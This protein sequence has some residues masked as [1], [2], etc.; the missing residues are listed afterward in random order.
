MAGAGYRVRA[1]ELASAGQQVSGLV[2]ECVQLAGDVAQAVSALAA[3]AGNPAVESAARGMGT[4]AL[5]QYIGAGSGLR[6]T[7]EQLS[8]TA[9][10]YAKAESD[11]VSSV[12]GVA[13]RLVG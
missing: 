11:S 6:H 9:Q 1:G 7:A 4:S 2:S 8:G 12:S 13:S 3:A 10:T 5:R